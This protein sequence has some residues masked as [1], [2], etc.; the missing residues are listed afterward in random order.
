M[1]ELAEH[2]GISTLTDGHFTVGSYV[3]HTL[4]EM[5]KH[6]DAIVWQNHTL[7]VEKMDGRRIDQLLV[8]VVQTEQ[9]AV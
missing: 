7:T 4:R 6:G 9:E 3:F 8:E 1:D 2:L 5:P